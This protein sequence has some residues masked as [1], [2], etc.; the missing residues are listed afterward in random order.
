MVLAAGTI[1]AVAALAAPTVIS[2][3]GSENGAGAYGG[4]SALAY[5]TWQSSG[6]RSM[7]GGLALLSTTV[8]TPTLLPRV[9]TGTTMYRINAA[10]AGQ[11]AVL[12]SFSMTTAAPLSTEIELRFVAGTSGSPTHITAYVETPNPGAGAAITFS[13]YFDAGTA[14]ANGFTVE[15]AQAVA[16]ACPTVGN[17]P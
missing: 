11:S 8:G 14:P 9:A 10:T 1:L 16:L 3:G 7:P 13:F 17:C 2:A 4:Q 5:W 12:W 6:F 15:T